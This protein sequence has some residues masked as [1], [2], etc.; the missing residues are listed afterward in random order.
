MAGTAA[1]SSA[2]KID[3]AERQRRALILRRDG[4]TYEVI[5]KALG[6]SRKG[7]EYAVKAAIAKLTNPIAEE[8]RQIHYLRLERAWLDLQPAMRRGETDAVRAGVQVLKRE[9]ALFGL[10]AP[11]KIDVGRMATQ[12]AERYGLSP[13]ERD[14]LF[15]AVR[16]ELATSRDPLPA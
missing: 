11:V 6:Y 12:Y 4:A 9:A 16:E 1:K 5:G 3:A 8:L 2:I 7:A 13:D 10:D 14:E 15:L